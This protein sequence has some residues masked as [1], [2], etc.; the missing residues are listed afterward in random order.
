MSQFVKG[1]QSLF[2]GPDTKGQEAEAAR[3]RQDQQITLDRQR[4]ELQN[5]QATE[6]AN[7]GKAARA[8]RG[9]RLLLAATGE[10]GVSN[11]L[12]GT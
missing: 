1:I 5:Q 7:L 3:Q 11:N 2:S 9:R 4:Q 6:D 12:S 8:P 10:Q